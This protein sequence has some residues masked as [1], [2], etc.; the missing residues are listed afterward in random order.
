MILLQPETAMTELQYVHEADFQAEVLDAAGPVLVDFTAPWCGPCKMVDPIV[1]QLAGEW[2]DK[3]HVLKCDADKNP[4]ILIQYGIM[5]IPT[6][7]LF[8]HG[9]VTERVTGYQSREKLST[10]FTRHLS[11]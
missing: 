8:Q 10:R 7:L 11:P 5:G 6:L 4:N 1:Q 3:V 9:K 2:G